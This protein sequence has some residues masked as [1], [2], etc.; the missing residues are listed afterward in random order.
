MA[1]IDHRLLVNKIEHRIELT[2]EALVEAHPEMVTATMRGRVKALR[3][4]LNEIED[5]ERGK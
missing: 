2:M 3:E 4:I 1:T 5:M